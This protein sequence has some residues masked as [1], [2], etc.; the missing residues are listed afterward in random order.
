LS[1]AATLSN[2]TRYKEARA[3]KTLDVSLRK[4]YAGYKDSGFQLQAEF[5]IAPGI[6]IVL[7]HSGAGK[8]TLLRCI[9]GLC[10][11]EEGR[12]ATGGQVLFDAA[13]GI[14]VP[15]ARRNVG[16]VFQDLALF[17]HLTVAENVAYGLRRLAPEERKERINRVLESFHIA[18]LQKRLPRAISGGEQQRVALARSLVTEPCVLLLDEPL[19]SLDAG[20]KTGIIEDIRRWNEEHEIPILYVT[21]NHEEVR[22]LGENLF[23]LDHGRI[24][25][26]RGSLHVASPALPTV[27]GSGEVENLLDATVIE[28]QKQE[29]TMTCRI[30]GT[31]VD[32]TAP[33]AQVSPGAQVRL[34]I[35]AGEILMASSRP[36]MVGHCNLIRGNVRQVQPSGD[37]I[38]ARVDCG[39]EFRVHLRANS[40]EREWLRSL[41]DAWMIIRPHVC[42][43]LDVRQLSAMQRLFIFVCRGNTL[44][45]PMAQAICNAEVARLLNIPQ[46]ASRMA[47]ITAISAGLAATPGEAMAAEAQRVLG[48]LSVPA[49][50]HRSQNLSAELAAQAE[51]I[52]CMTKKQCQMA[53]QLFPTAAS[54]VFCL[55]PEA[56]LD[57]PD[58]S[59]PEA[60]LSLAVTIQSLICQRLTSLQNVVQF[61]GGGS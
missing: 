33:L 13:Q 57:E 50:A 2:E 56:D 53:M 38:E 6:T 49:F 58:K 34:G 14:N 35:R 21:H 37:G 25:S 54:K 41:K 5:S 12:I 20:M 26:D 42:Q 44:R 52:F 30:R 8:S 28:L 17:P 48:R 59:D 39:V 27:V 4:R 16:F 10:D 9:A 7:G 32:L 31:S 45:S 3:G 15:P 11:L 40:A 36:E 24:V 46:E 29:C 19:S 23:T 55:H 22:A 18:H 60:V 51:A 43:V 61:P 1:S 47:G